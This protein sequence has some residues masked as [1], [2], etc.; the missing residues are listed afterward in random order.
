MKTAIAETS[1]DVWVDCPCC[2]EYVNATEDLKE[3]LEDDLRAEDIEEHVT[4]DNKECKE[5]FIVTEITY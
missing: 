4:C 1:L 5:I 2:G 3:S